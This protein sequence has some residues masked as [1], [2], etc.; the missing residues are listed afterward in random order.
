[1]TSALGHEEIDTSIKLELLERGSRAAR[2]RDGD[3]RI[4]ADRQKTANLSR[5]DRIEYLAGSETGTGQ[6]F[7]RDA[8][9]IGD[10]PP[11]LGILD[12]ARARQLITAL[13]VLASAL[14]VSLTCDRSVAGSGFSD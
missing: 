14:A 5:F 8:P 4:E 2:V 13:A 10:E 6:A 3:H 12:V 1:M 7:F 9:E 11:V